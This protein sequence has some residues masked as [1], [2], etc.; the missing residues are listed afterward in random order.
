MDH[1][2]RK[3]S[4]LPEIMPLP[5]SLLES[6]S[7]DRHTNS[8]LQPIK[9]KKKKKA[10]LSKMK[11]Y[12]TIKGGRREEGCLGRFKSVLVTPSKANRTGEKKMFSH[13]LS[14]I[15]A[16]LQPRKGACL[17][18]DQLQTHPVLLFK[19]NW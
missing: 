4:F 13:F 8:A 2:L 9:G 19:D 1:K 16:A 15:E 3:H 6:H 18:E 5:Y 17:C 14:N 12:G 10:F 11:A 7:L